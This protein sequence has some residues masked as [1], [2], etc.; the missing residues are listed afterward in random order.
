MAANNARNTVV[1]TFNTIVYQTRSGNSHVNLL[2][3]EQGRENGS[4]VPLR[5]C[6]YLKADCG[7]NLQVKKA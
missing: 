3:L 4:V 6:V 5:C 1:G 7:V 2:D